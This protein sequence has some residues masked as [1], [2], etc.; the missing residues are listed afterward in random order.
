MVD[1][2]ESSDEDAQEA[3]ALAVSRRVS[4][5]ATKRKEGGSR[6]RGSLLLLGGGLGGG[7]GRHGA[8][9]AARGDVARLLAIKTN[10]G[11]R[12]HNR[13]RRTLKELRKRTLT[14]R[15][16]RPTAII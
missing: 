3:S 8:I 6:K 1:Q 11:S 4:K 15:S 14:R 2:G 5:K 10:H 16:P 13:Q 12:R 9:R 7:C